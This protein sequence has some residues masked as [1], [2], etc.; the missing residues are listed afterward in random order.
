MEAER[1][2]QTSA[3]SQSDIH[4]LQGALASLQDENIT[5]RSSLD[6][7][8]SM[9]ERLHRKLHD[10]VLA[11]QRLPG[12]DELLVE[13]GLAVAQS[14]AQG[15]LTREDSLTI[16][17]D[18]C[19]A[20]EVFVR[21]TLGDLL[22]R[23]YIDRPSSHRELMSWFQPYFACFEDELKERPDTDLNLHCGSGFGTLLSSV[24]LDEVSAIREVIVSV[25]I[26]GLI[27]QHPFVPE[28][29]AV[30][31]TNVA[32]SSCCDDEEEMRGKESATTIS[33]S[34]AKLPV[35]SGD[36]LVRVSSFLSLRDFRG[37]LLRLCR[38]VRKQLL[39]DFALAVATSRPLGEYCGGHNINQRVGAPPPPSLS[40]LFLVRPAICGN[41]LG[42]GASSFGSRN[43]S[44]VGGPTRP[45]RLLDVCLHQPR[46]E[47]NVN[48]ASSS[49]TINASHCHPAP[50][51]VTTAAAACWLPAQ[52]LLDATLRHESF[53]DLMTT[54]YASFPPGPRQSFPA[55]FCNT[56]PDDES[57][58]IT[59]ARSLVESPEALRHAF[60][61]GALINVLD[62]V[63]K[64]YDAIILD[65]RPRTNEVLVHYNR[66]S[67]RWDEWIPLCVPSLGSTAVEVEFEWNSR[68]QPYGSRFDHEGDVLKSDFGF[69]QLTWAK[70]TGVPASEATARTH[71]H[72]QLPAALVV[73]HNVAFS[74]S[75]RRRNTFAFESGAERTAV[76]SF[77]DPQWQSV[78]IPTIFSHN[79][80]LL[81]T[82]AGC[83]CIVREAE[84]RDML[85]MVET[86]YIPND[87]LVEF[88]RPATRRRGRRG[89]GTK[90]SNVSSSSHG[91]VD[92]DND[93][94]NLPLSAVAGAA[95]APRAS[96]SAPS[97]PQG[98]ALIGSRQSSFHEGEDEERSGGEQDAN[99]GDDADENE[100]SDDPLHMRRHHHD[101][102]GAAP[103]AHPAAI[104]R[105]VE[106]YNT[107]TVNAFFIVINCFG[108]GLLYARYGARHWKHA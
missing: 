64:W 42:S 56:V 26:P 4:V 108:E 22:F 84:E 30:D 3:V 38:S 70:S 103:S 77:L 74:S 87:K 49:D 17:A 53:L 93:R 58:F 28:I 66:W 83:Q 91:A 20:T 105:L 85:S 62:T 34:D 106:I 12:G 44:R 61:P 63:R 101:G 36:V 60:R 92:S 7:A 97:S 102:G 95:F 24:Q 68:L 14:N 82:I 94:G 88:L 1:L 96:S 9:I 48:S 43:L 23:V 80:K 57:G 32:S 10:T 6:K 31:T 25:T 11:V 15:L 107:Q 52:E 47:M 40:R 75:Q 76:C 37:G 18:S 27:T 35:F 90:A 81:Q 73:D 104:C 71:A 54:R 69:F 79:Q 29:N 45:L 50:E 65:I 100:E 8:Q 21:N 33:H 55:D 59:P 13:L 16:A 46:F 78:V 86:S 67:N 51:M 2:Q 98:S 41:I 99:D 5:L 39:V 19:V 72:H 89:A